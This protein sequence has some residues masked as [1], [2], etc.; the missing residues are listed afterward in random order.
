MIIWAYFC[1]CIEYQS[2]QVDGF[3]IQNV[4]FYQQMN[5][6]NDFWKVINMEKRGN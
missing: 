6:L 3:I 4:I 2:T 5:N 1:V